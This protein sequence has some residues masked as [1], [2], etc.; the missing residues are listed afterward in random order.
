MENLTRAVL[1]GICFGIWPLVMNKSGLSGNVSSLALTLIV[2][3]V[4]G[5]ASYGEIGKVTNANWAALIVASLLSAGGLLLLNGG[6]ATISARE[7]GTFF[8]TITI[9]QICIPA[10]YHVVQNGVT[11]DKV[12]GFMFAGFAIYFLSR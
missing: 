6:L 1:A 10:L 5:V 3:A 8:L 12:L 2:L 4:V 7:V 9:V 11:L